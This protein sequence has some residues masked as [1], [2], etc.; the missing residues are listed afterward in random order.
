MVH[1]YGRGVE[2]HIN[3][4]KP[5]DYFDIV[6]P[7]EM[8]TR[9]RVY[10][11]KNCNFISLVRNG[12]S[13]ERANKSGYIEIANKV[14]AEEYARKCEHYKN[15]NDRHSI[16]GHNVED[17]AYRNKGA[18]ADFTYPLGSITR[19]QAIEDHHLLV[20]TD[21][22]KELLETIR[23][24]VGDEIESEGWYEVYFFI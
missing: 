10:L 18:W 9:R 6:P 3:F 22:E 1:D 16:V 19:K 7:I 17:Y 11:N 14:D 2:Y 15:T 21:E 12:D 13:I 20:L 24:V 5:V 23:N 4:K 8:K